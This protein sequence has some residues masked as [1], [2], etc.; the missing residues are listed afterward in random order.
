MSAEPNT[1]ATGKEVAVSFDHSWRF[2]DGKV[3][4]HRRSE[5]TLG[6]PT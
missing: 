4:Y 1:S 2:R 6:A 3:A 5:D